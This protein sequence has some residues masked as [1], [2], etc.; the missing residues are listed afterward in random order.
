MVYR[1]TGWAT[2]IAAG[3]KV[4]VDGV[5][6]ANVGHDQFKIVALPSGLRE[7]RV[8]GGGDF[9][10]CTKALFIE[11]NEVN[12]LRLGPNADHSSALQI[13][14]PLAGLIKGKADEDRTRCGGTVEPF[15]VREAAAKQEMRQ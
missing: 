13:L 7:V 14:F 11:P 6:V 4:F 8:A 3:V 1:K 5:E 10:S 12:Y 9:S 15:M 2:G